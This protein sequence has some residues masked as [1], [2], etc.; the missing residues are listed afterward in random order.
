[1]RCALLQLF[2]ISLSPPL[3]Q[4]AALQNEYAGGVA[5]AILD[6]RDFVPER[7]RSGLG[8]LINRACSCSANLFRGRQA[9]AT[10]RTRG[11]VSPHHSSFRRP[12]EKAPSLLSVRIHKTTLEVFTRHDGMPDYI[13][14]LVPIPNELINH[15]GNTI[16][17]DNL[18]KTIQHVRN[19]LWQARPEE[20]RHN[21]REYGAPLR[22]MDVDK[23]AVDERNFELVRFAKAH[24]EW[25]QRR[26]ELSE[27]EEVQR[28]ELQTRTVALFYS[29]RGERV[30]EDV[31]QVIR[32]VEMRIKR[33]REQLTKAAAE[34][35]PGGEVLSGEAVIHLDTLSDF[36]FEY[37]SSQELNALLDGR[38]AKEDCA[39]DFVEQYERR[40]RESRGLR[41]S[42]SSGSA[43]PYFG[44]WEAREN[45]E[46]VSPEPV[47]FEEV[48]LPE[49]SVV[50]H[51][52]TL[53]YRGVSPTSV[54]AV[55][56]MFQPKEEVGGLRGA[57]RTS[58]VGTPRRPFL[59]RGFPSEV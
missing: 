53:E 50:P 36:A 32:T 24:Q 10:P 33:I 59:A 35:R 55:D 11:R 2:L 37:A 43:A 14:E 52:K 5:S 49:E 15:D 38:L 13:D 26:L 42:T 31:A 1:M 6:S 29:A 40:K 45:G 20:E 4:S 22:V 23:N 58:P 12:S 51:S 34:G 3:V 9:T 28:L 57:A 21:M 16:T 41:V 19:A 30:P 7:R 17:A 18:K 56:N 8:R 48:R 39:S 54:A 27:E 44:N 47:A 25:A 46:P